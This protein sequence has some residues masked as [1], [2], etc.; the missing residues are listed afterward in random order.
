M[1]N[2]RII[3]EKCPRFNNCSANLCP[4][5]PEKTILN[6]KRKYSAGIKINLN[7]ILSE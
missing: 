1:E 6:N 2:Y 7:Y 3:Q 4:Y 5:D